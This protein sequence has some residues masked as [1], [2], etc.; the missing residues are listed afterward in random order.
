MSEDRKESITALTKKLVEFETTKDKQEELEECL[1]YIESY[2]AEEVKVERFEQNGKPS[3]LAGF[4]DVK[5]PQIL[6]HGH[7]DVVE[8]PEEM[9]RPEIREEKLYGRGTADMKAGV[10]CIVELLNELSKSSDPPSVAMV[11]V[12]DEEVGGFDGMGYMI[13]EKDLKPKFGLSAEPDANN[14][15]S[16]VNKQK[17]VLQLNVVCEGKSAHG[18]SP[19]NG[20]NAIEK[21][22]KQYREIEKLFNSKKGFRTTLNLGTIQGGKCV[23][24]VPEKAEMELDIRY[25]EEYEA[26][27]IISDLEEKEIDFE[28]TARAPMLE[29]DPEEIYV[30]KLQKAARDQGFSAEMRKENYASDMRFLTDRNIPAVVFG[31]HGENIHGREEFVNIKSIP[32]YFKILKNFIEA[33]E[34]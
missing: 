8:A 11:I 34:N 22:M 17:G 3:M 24:Q 1:D 25:T 20:V 19:E 32:E 18:S 12:S 26:D 9:F 2:L 4:K 21:L 10:A 16:I 13:E 7:I 31:P 28:V 5:S 33:T 30:K 23:N 6:L 14:F 15:P 27:E 29:T